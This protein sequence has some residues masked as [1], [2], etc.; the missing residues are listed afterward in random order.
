MDLIHDL[1]NEIVFALLV[2]KKY[3]DRLQSKEVLPLVRKI[4]E[5]LQVVSEKD[6][7]EPEPD[8]FVTAG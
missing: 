7:S 2:E 6:H 3:G 4:G 5:V 8:F 1:G